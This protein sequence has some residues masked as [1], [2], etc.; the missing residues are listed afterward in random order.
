MQAADAVTDALSERRAVGYKL[1]W[2]VSSDI[3][4]GR[5]KM[6]IVVEEIRLR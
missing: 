2:R 5:L 6:S 3:A 4:G 1:N